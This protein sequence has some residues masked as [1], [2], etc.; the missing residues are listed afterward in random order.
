M[1]G[2][3]AIIILETGQLGIGLAIILVFGNRKVRVPRWRKKRGGGA[4]HSG[5]TLQR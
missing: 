5:A 4:L 2:E 3:A 1:D